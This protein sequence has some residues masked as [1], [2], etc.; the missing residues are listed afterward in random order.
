MAQEKWHL[1][2]SVPIAL[3]FAILIQCGAW[4]WSL[5]KLQSNVKNNASDIIELQKSERNSRELY[6]RIVRLEVLIER[7]LEEMKKTNER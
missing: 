7:V 2:K 3:I 6:E 4:I 5:S 1:N